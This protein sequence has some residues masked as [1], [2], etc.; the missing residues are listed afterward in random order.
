MKTSAQ[1]IWEIMEEF[2]V[3]RK[4]RTKM[5]HEYRVPQ[6]EEPMRGVVFQLPSSE[7]VGYVVK[8]GSTNNGF[9]IITNQDIEFEFEDTKVGS[10][11]RITYNGYLTNS[12]DEKNNSF[13]FNWTSN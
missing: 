4:R 3:Q 13:I 6:W 12:V 10:K 5:C 2:R 8:S 1:Q 11:V 7:H 9:Y